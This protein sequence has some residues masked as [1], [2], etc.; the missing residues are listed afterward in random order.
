MKRKFI[1]TILLSVL[2]PPVLYAQNNKFTIEGK[3]KTNS[4]LHGMIYLIGKNVKPDSVPLIN[5]SYYFA[6]ILERPGAAIFITWRDR[7]LAK[8]LRETKSALETG[9]SLLFLAPGNI[10][11]EHELNFKH[12]KVAGSKLHSDYDSIRREIAVNKKNVDTVLSTYIWQHPDSWFGFIN[13]QQKVKVF[14]PQLSQ[15]LYQN[16]STN[17]KQYSEVTDLGKQIAAMQTSSIGKTAPDFTLNTSDGQPISLSSYRGKYVL[18]DFW[19]SWCA[20]CRAE[21]PTV[22]GVYNLYKDSGFDVLGVSLDLAPSKPQWIAAI[23]QDGLTWA[24]VSDLKGFDSDIAIKYGVHSIPA[25]FL[26]DPSGK[27]IASNLRGY[28]LEQKM[29]QLFKK[30]GQ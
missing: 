12:I 3:I 5:N 26:I 30:V 16:L 19:A 9:S 8:Q 18:L 20:P 25:N 23:K 24:Q 15:K 28:E 21:S 10:H 7:P 13:L 2:L 22:K 29:K 4:V 6:G 14:R 27:I 1:I 17:L 11:V